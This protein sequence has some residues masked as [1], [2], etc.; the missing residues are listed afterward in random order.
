MLSFEN[1]LITFTEWLLPSKFN[2]MQPNTWGFALGAF[3]IIFLLSILSPFFW[4]VIASFSRGPN[5]AFNL[6]SRSLLST[7]REDA[8]GFSFRLD[9]ARTSPVA[10]CS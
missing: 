4:F 1:K 2:I 10:V 9:S 7:F 5:E 6:V 8:P 3:V